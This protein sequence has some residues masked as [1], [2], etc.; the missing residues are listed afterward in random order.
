MKLKDFY[1]NFEASK[2]TAPSGAGD[3][4]YFKPLLDEMLMHFIKLM[5]VYEEKM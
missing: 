3:A 5:E 4:S 2:L 1:L